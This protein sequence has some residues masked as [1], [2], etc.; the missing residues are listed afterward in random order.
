MSRLFSVSIVAS[1]LLAL[2][3]VAQGSVNIFDNGDFE[4]GDLDPSFQDRAPQFGVAPWTVVSAN[5]LT[6]SFDPG[7]FSA[8]AAGDTELRR[9]FFSFADDIRDV[10]EDISAAGGAAFGGQVTQISFWVAH[11]DPPASKI[12][13]TLFY[14]DGSSIEQEYQT[15]TTGWEFFDITSQHDPLGDLTGIS[16]FGNV[17]GRTFLDDIQVIVTVPEPAAITLLLAS[18][19]AVL[20]VRR[21]QH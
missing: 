8:L 20:F 9:D 18:I 14:D 6:G 17:S 10:A 12:L 3:P 7:E 15:L 1:T 5:S 19:A 4:S 16:F 21:R 11:P 13:V 2:L